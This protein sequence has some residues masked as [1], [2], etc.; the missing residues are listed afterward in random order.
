[1]D[2]LA[3]VVEV[4]CRLPGDVASVHFAAERE[5]AVGFRRS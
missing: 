2:P 3:A 5:V 1:L 4:P